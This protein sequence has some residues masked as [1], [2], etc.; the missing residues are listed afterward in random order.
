MPAPWTDLPGRPFTGGRTPGMGRANRASSAAT[1]VERKVRGP[2]AGD[3]EGCPRLKGGIR[4]S[5]R[6]L[7]AALKTT[8]W[9]SFMPTVDLLMQVS[10]YSSGCAILHF[11]KRDLEL[12]GDE[13]RGGTWLD[14]REGS[15]RRQ[16]LKKR[17]NSRSGALTDEEIIRGRQRAVEEAAA[18]ARRE[19]Y[20]PSSPSLIAANDTDASWAME[21]RTQTSN[22]CMLLPERQM[23]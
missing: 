10:C 21:L 2:P 12:A 11:T 8:A 3:I 14:S 1:P 16:R 9:P 20:C 19:N 13:P 18:M 5:Q 23:T 6:G 15:R 4:I 22:F 7:P 17:R